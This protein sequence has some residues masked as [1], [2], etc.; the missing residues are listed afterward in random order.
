MELARKKISL[1]NSQ[2]WVIREI[3]SERQNKYLESLLVSSKSLKCQTFECLGISN[4][5]STF[6]KFRSWNSRSLESRK[7]EFIWH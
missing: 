2:S 7:E 3:A 1:E 4:N 6:K 5:S